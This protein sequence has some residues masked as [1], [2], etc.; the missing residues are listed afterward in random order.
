MNRLSKILLAIGLA[1]LV[2]GL[3]VSHGGAKLPPQLTVLFPAGVILTGVAVITI[4]THDED[5]KLRQDERRKLEQAPARPEPSSHPP[6][7]EL[8]RAA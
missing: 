4:L 2:G 8:E 5:E 3:Y 6:H 7:T 1:L